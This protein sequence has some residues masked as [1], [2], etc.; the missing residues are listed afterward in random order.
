[1][2]YLVP[3]VTP[4]MLPDIL[5]QTTERYPILLSLQQ[6]NFLKH[7][8]SGFWVGTWFPRA[9]TGCRTPIQIPNFNHWATLSPLSF[10]TDDHCMVGA[11][12][13]IRVRWVFVRGIPAVINLSLTETGIIWTHFLEMAKPTPAVLSSPPLQKMLW[14]LS[15]MLLV[16]GN[17]TSLNA[18]TSMFAFLSSL[19]MIAVARSGLMLGSADVPRR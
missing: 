13:L 18:H 16:P 15:L 3:V 9:E 7:S 12:T 10:S 1:M 6:K 8:W 19:Q 14:L 5:F 11:R 17:L 4:L 2:I